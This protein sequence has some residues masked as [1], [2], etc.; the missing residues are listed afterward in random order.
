MRK[1]LMSLALVGAMLPPCANAILIVDT[2]TPT[3]GPSYSFNAGQYFGGEF[4]IEDAYQVGSVEAYFDNSFGTARDVEVSIHHDGGNV[5]GAEIYSTTI[6]MPATSTPDWHGAFGLD[7]S[8]DAGTYW[9]SFIPDG[10]V[11]GVMP[12]TAPNP[13]DEYSVG[14]GAG[15]LNVAEN[16][17]DNLGM[18]FRIGTNTGV[19]EPSTL[20]LMG[21]GL[22]GI[23]FARRKKA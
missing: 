11:S 22:S 15:W 12:G 9:V 16:T 1:A 17:Y 3:G 13:L 4:S 20:A 14:I 7:W 2:G 5:P 21:I 10:Q 6:S 8:L 23:G 19:P 18:G